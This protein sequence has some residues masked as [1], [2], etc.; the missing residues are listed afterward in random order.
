MSPLLAKENKGHNSITKKIVK[1]EIELGLRFMIPGL[2]TYRYTARQTWVQLNAH[3][4]HGYNLM[5]IMTSRW[6]IK[7]CY[8]SILIA[9]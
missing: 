3:D 2:V 9:K 7:T 6:G 1:S 8:H 4:R 5:F